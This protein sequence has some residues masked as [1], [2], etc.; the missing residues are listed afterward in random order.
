MLELKLFL[1]LI[2]ANSA[3]VVARMLLADHWQVAI[4]GGRL[5]ADGRPLLGK[6]KTWRGII[7]AVLLCAL[8]APLINFPIGMAILISLMSM[9][10]D[11]CSSFIKRR[12]GRPVS[13]QALLLDQI[14]EALFPLLAAQALLDISW[15]AVIVISVAFML[16]ELLLS[17]VLF[18]WGIRK[19]PY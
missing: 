3:P 1:L 13:S 17:P 15:A 18:K 10:G 14:P 4:D 7:A 11:L 8:A 16:T 5:L 12:L 6:S 2:I 9:S 19:R